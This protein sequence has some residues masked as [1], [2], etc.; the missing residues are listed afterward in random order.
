[1]QTE[2][3]IK[4]L[5]VNVDEI[6]DKLKKLNA[7]YI[8]V[9]N[10]KRYVYDFKP[11][12]YEKR[13]RL[14]TDW[15]TSTLCIKDIQD[16][17]KIDWTKE[18]EIVVDNFDKT[19]QILEMLWYNFRAYQENIRT[20]YRLKGCDVEIDQRPMIP[21]YLEIE[22]QSTESVKNILILLWL[23]NNITTS[24]NTTAVY[25]RYWIDDLEKIR[26]LKF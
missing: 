14:R 21:T 24:E 5:D 16:E 4:V 20:S 6:K 15:D 3:E 18:L 17:S 9:K 1:M 2:F 11:A 8:W 22:G 7:E 13:V 19:N 25:K 10:Q 23:E 12:C 26:E